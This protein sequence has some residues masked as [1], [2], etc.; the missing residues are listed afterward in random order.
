MSGGITV[1]SAGPRRCGTRPRV[2]AF[3]TR[4]VT[5]SV[6]GVAG[7]PASVAGAAAQAAGIERISIDE[8]VARA[9]EKNP[10]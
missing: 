8:A 10:R 4:L 5:A 9:V 1:R 6:L 3:L 7:A 2:R